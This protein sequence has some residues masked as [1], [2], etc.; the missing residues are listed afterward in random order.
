MLVYILLY[1]SHVLLVRP[2]V[3]VFKRNVVFNISTEWYEVTFVVEQDELNRF[4]SFQLCSF[5]H[6]W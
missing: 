5:K 1:F 3:F 4:Y 6:L 2:K